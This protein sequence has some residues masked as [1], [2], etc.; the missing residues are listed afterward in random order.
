MSL[1]NLSPSQKLV[2][3]VS[4]AMLGVVA[5]NAPAAATTF[6]FESAGGG[7][8]VAGNFENIST[9]F[10][11]DSSLFTWS[12]TLSRNNNNL[13]DGGWLVISDGPNP[14]P[15]SQ[16]YTIF[17]LDGANDSVSAYDYSGIHRR[18]SWANTN[19]LG[20]SDLTTTN[21]GDERTFDFAFDMSTINSRTDFGPDWKGTTFTDEIGIWY[22]A[23][24][25]L[26]TDY[27][28][29]GQLSQ[30]DFRTD[31]WFD[32]ASRPTQSFPDVSDE[33]DTQDVPEPTAI[34]GLALL[35]AFVF[36]RKSLSIV[37]KIV[38]A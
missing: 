24:D 13:A 19:F 33:P 11:T 5:L 30:F 6:T 8:S 21:A 15:L 36:K 35:L 38:G 16:E 7:N 1:P 23:L 31:G 28:D 27:D 29:S 22:H 20:T 37:N 34:T 4:S 17:Y 25:G 9:S 32:V 26:V 3:V 12:S 10:N 14:R 18:F 2:G